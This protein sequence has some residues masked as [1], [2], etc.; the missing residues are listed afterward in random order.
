MDVEKLIDDY[1]SKK[2][3]FEEKKQDEFKDAIIVNALKKYQESVGESIYIVSDDNGFL[4][5]FSNRN[6]FLVFKTLQD[7]LKCYNYNEE[8]DLINKS[9]D[10]EEFADKL[11]SY[12]DNHDIFIDSYEEYDINDKGINN[13]TYECY[14]IKEEFKKRYALISCDIEFLIDITYR[15]EDMSYYDKEERKYL[16]ENYI[17]AIEEHKVNINLKVFFDI[18]KEDTKKLLLQEIG[19][20]ENNHSKIIY[21]DDN[22]MIS[23][24]E[25]ISTMDEEQ[26]LEKC[27]ECGKV[28][29]YD[30]LYQDY[31][32]KPLCRECMKSDDYGN[33]CPECGRKIPNEYMISGYCQDCFYEKDC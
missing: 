25:L 3:P 29:Y 11:Y 22:T 2:P 13:I 31:E 32:G 14:C 4:K 17:H 15:D 6:K 16:F 19:S 1:Y 12:I 10:S 7:F 27:S 20:I 26:N 30:Y 21:L 33:I 5:A 23:N 8:M 28:I 24:E 9:I 18:K